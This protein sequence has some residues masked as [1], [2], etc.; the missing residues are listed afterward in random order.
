MSEFWSSFLS[1]FI[2]SAIVAIAFYIAITQQVE[3]KQQET[4]V[5]QALGML[6]TELEINFKRAKTYLQ[7][8]QSVKETGVVPTARLR[9]TRGVW[10]ALKENGFLLQLTDPRLVYYL[11]RANETIVVADNSLYKLRNANPED[12]NLPSL[13]ER[14]QQD[15]SR[16][17]HALNTALSLFSNMS[18]PNYSHEEFDEVE[19]F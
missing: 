2:S 17:L 8:I 1:N 10:N 9:Y 11:L 7:E 14:A 6:K 19:W 5:K 16:L 18:L 15:C 12:G 13:I 3:K 4:Q